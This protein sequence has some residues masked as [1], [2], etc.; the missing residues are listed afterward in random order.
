LKRLLCLVLLFVG[1]AAIS[2]AGIS[3]AQEDPPPASSVYL[4]LISQGATPETPPAPTPSPTPEPPFDPGPFRVASVLSTARVEVPAV[5]KPGARSRTGQPLPGVD[6]P[7][8]GIIVQLEGE[9]LATYRGDIPGIPATSPRSAGQPR[10]DPESP[11]SRAYLDYLDKQ[12]RAFVQSVSRV[13]PSARVLHTYRTVFNGMAMVVPA[14]AVK[15]VAQ[16]PGVAAVFVD[17]LQP[18]ATER[19]PYFIGAPKLWRQLGGVEKAGEGVIIGVID[20]GIWP[21]HP[22]FS[23]PDPAG[24]PYP[25]PPRYWRGRECDFGN[26]AWNPN[27]RPFR[28]NNKLIGAA[29]FL[30]GYKALVGLLPTE[31]DSARDSNGHGT[32]TASTAAGNAGVRAVLLGVAR[33]AVSGIAPR[34]HVA[35][36]RACGD[37]GCYVSDLL[38]AI[39]QAIFDGVDVINYSIAGGEEPYADPVE[40]AFLAAYE[41][42]VFVAASAGN[43]GPA[44]DTVSH[45]SPW[46]TTVAAS[47]TDRHFLSTLTLRAANGETLRLTGASVT[48]GIDTPTPVVFP[49]E[50]QEL[51]LTP[52]PPGTFDGQIVICRRGVIPRVAKSY[53]VRAGGARGLILYNPEF[54]GVATD[55][56][57]LPTIHLEAD[58]GKRL[59]DFV[60][61]RPGVVA[62]FTPGQAT[63]VRGDVMA[64]FSSRGG[65]GQTLGVSKPDLTAPGVQILAGHTPMPATLV[66]GVPGQLFQAIQG[67]SMASPHVAG[68]AALLRAL[69]PTWTPGQIKSALMFTARTRKVVKEDGVTPG[70][71]FDYGSGRLSLRKAGDPGL[72][73]DE[74]A[75]NYLRLRNELWSANYPSLYVPIMPGRITV[76]RTVRNETGKR[77]RWRLKVRAPKDV[78]I[79]VPRRLVLP[80]YGTA[81]FRITVDARDVP[82]GEVRHATLTLRGRKNR[83]LRFPITIVRRQ[84][85]VTLETWCE[86]AE[87]LRGSPTRCTVQAT[88]TGFEPASVEIVDR[89]PRRLKLDP[90]SVQGATVV[91]RREIRFSGTLAPAEPPDVTVVDGTGTSPVG[92][93]LPLEKLGVSPIPGVTDETI[94]NL[95]TP[96]FLFLGQTWTQIGLVSNGYA[97]VGGGTVDDVQ[98]INQALP[99]PTPPNNVLA[100]FWT[101]LNPEAGG[102]VYAAVITDGTNQWI[103]LEW[104]RVPEFDDGTPASFQIWIGLNGVEDI[105]FV[106]GPVGDGNRGLL[107]VGAENQLGNRGSSW[108]VNGTGALPQ[109]G[110]ELR[111][112]STPGA[113]GETHVITFVAEGKRKGTYRNCPEM[114]SDAFFGTNIVCFEGRVVHKVRPI[115]MPLPA[116][117]DDHAQEEHDRQ[118]DEDHDDDEDDEDDD[119]HNEDDDHNDDDGEDG[120]DPGDGD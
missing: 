98:F 9:S 108:Y 22:S 105:S 43:A 29:T 74:S 66:G 2:L 65:P 93:Y 61:T 94:V 35:V 59:L 55:N 39:E 71:P 27:D 85:V 116:E 73:M 6:R 84:P 31:F 109:A 111:V 75:R 113:P 12:H 4:P 23:D 21:E 67:T 45:R 34:A 91:S 51:C 7:L 82:L 5:V 118:D 104:A 38:A 70:D 62:T 60:N 80:P 115:P 26:T 52:F 18:L 50:G 14:D 15:E 11:Q 92:G 37:A 28:C 58:A 24:K 114:T 106:Y 101:D 10:L 102:A 49:P 99:D 69:H 81:T 77:A 112:I 100:P 32:H 103:V 86:P 44:P 76:E 42:G 36:Y 8:V 90:D 63:R 3:H 30:E 68:A 120:E 19:S 33:G 17:E 110:T 117:D 88:N 25:R 13:A 78:K 97:V 79:R 54:Q 72:T 83:R 46:V 96:P 87:I 40:L 56:H 48:Q 1:W 119:A 20:S 107:T 64:A 53:N 41:A 47:T 95:G 89:I 57:F 16:L